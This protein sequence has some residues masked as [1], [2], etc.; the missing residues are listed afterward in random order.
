MAGGARVALR[1]AVTG[2]CSG[3]DTRAMAA[4]H[5]DLSRRAGEGARDARGV[6][7]G[8]LRPDASL[9]ADVERLLAAHGDADAGSFG[10]APVF[11]QGESPRLESGTTLGQY[12]ITH[13]IGAGGMGEIYLAEDARLNR[14][15]R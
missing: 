11:V 2:E 13:F 3:D 12:C 1:A 4:S 10:A 6:S 14:A 7:A 9:R 8:G 15:S 5:R